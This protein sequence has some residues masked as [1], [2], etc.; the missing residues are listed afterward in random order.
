[1][2][3]FAETYL[4]KKK[5]LKI[6][7]VGSQ[8]VPEDVMGSYKRFFENK[9]ADW[10]YVGCDMVAGNNVDIVLK[11]VYNW[12]EIKT[13]SFDVVISGQA[14]EH[15]EYFWLTFFEIKRAL[16][17]GG[18]S[19]IIVPSAGYEHKY[20]LDCYRYYPDGLVA[21]AKYVG[22]EVLETYT[23][24]DREKYP[25]MDEIWKDSVIITRKPK[26]N[27]INDMKF[28]IKSNL[29]KFASHSAVY[30]NVS[31]ENVNEEEIQEYK[32]R[33]KSFLYFAVNQESF[34]EENKL[35]AESV[36]EKNG[37]FSLKFEL[38]EIKEAFSAIRF[39]PCEYPC[40]IDKLE[41]FIDEKPCSYV[42][43]NAMKQEDSKIIFKTSDP[44]ISLQP[45]DFA[46]IKIIIISGYLF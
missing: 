23:Q 3:R 5:S 45:E 38:N 40:S 34:N 18:I 32:Q 42:P 28:F 2:K 46:D 31:Y 14:L 39:D 15:V 20:P 19:C 11:N 33:L 43:Y 13:N 8:T 12:K 29:I 24:W 41:V 16:K 7:D 26:K 27:F 4:D 22:L 17:H 36:I 1:M 21:A 6:L 25:D 10:H 9:E 44:I 30:E 35:Y 37:H